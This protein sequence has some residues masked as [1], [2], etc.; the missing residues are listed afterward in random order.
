MEN[1]SN[2]DVQEVTTPQMETQEVFDT[3]ADTVQP[4]PSI[5]QTTKFE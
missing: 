5:T 1:V 2:A 3:G 4:N